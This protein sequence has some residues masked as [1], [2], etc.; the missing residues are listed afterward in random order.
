[1]SR[2]SQDITLGPV[3]LRVSDRAR[4]GDWLERVLGLTR[5][6]QA[7]WGT[8]DGAALVTLR[9]VAGA[10]PMLPRGRLGIYHYALRLP[11]RADLGRFLLHL[12]AMGEPFGASDHRVSEALYLTDPDGITVEVYA[13]RPRAEWTYQEGEV[14]ATIDPL[15]RPALVA[16][17]GGE[18]WAG[19]PARGDMGHLHFFVGDLAE[20]ERFYV[21]AIGFE[22]T[23]RRLRGALFVAAGG[24]HHHLGLNVWAA[25]QPVAGPEDA[26]LDEWELVLPAPADAE[27]LAIRAREAG[28]EVAREAGALV[29]TDPWRLRARV[30]TR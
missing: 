10:R 26:G 16:A 11:A 18:A 17:A 9:E 20:A 2:L 12:E 24:Y 1:M 4:T 19:F 8:A 22:P 3:A 21:D 29:L 13:D 25:G 6:E 7:R 14:V 27:A 30:V 15:D 23:T 28:V 5:L